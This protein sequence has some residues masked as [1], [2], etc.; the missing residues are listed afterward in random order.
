MDV[1]WKKSRRHMEGRLRC[2]KKRNNHFCCVL[3][4]MKRRWLFQT[5][6]RHLLFPRCIYIVG[7]LI[8]DE[9][10]LSYI[11]FDFLDCHDCIIFSSNE[12]RRLLMLYC[13]LT[14]LNMAVSCGVGF[15]IV[16][17]KWHG[18]INELARGSI[19]FDLSR[20]SILGTKVVR[21]SVM[22]R[23]G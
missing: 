8:F 3:Q 13:L 16:F 15:V 22:F 17:I 9:Y 20:C 18:Y 2:Y 11:L 19:W 10:C 7:K 14:R 21:V 23:K 5:P 1:W 12:E 4:D 6:H